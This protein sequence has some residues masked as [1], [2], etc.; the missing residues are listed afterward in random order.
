MSS[1]RAIAGRALQSVYRRMPVSWDT[2]LAIKNAVFTTFA[3]VLKH[4]NVYR[5]WY[6]FGAQ[7]GFVAV[8][9]PPA[10]LPRLPDPEISA[11][12]EPNAAAR[13][14]HD[15]LAL[16]R[17]P[18][19][20]HYVGRPADAPPAAVR[21]KAIAFYLPQ[22][23]PIAENDAW[24]GRGFTEWTNV[25]KAVPQFV[26]H[27]Q[28]KLPGELGFYDLRLV[29][30]MRRQ[31]QLVGVGHGGGLGAATHVTGAFAFAAVGKVLEK[32]LEPQKLKKD[33]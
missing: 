22:F 7:R 11:D 16:A 26:G 25:S 17:S 12:G 5:R 4:T 33:A 21:A 31:A 24:W 2:R 20:A 19:S 15:V 27:E 30:V 3:P 9:V 10:P 32:L 28:P 29:D 13:W 1:F 8:D 6:G 23:H 18:R 14:M